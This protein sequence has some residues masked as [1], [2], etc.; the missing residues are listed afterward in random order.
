MGLPGHCLLVGKGKTLPLKSPGLS[1]RSPG[2]PTTHKF[3]K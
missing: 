3:M 1:L 2:F